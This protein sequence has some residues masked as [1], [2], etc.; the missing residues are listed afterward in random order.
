MG[1][2]A[3]VLSFVRSLSNGAK[4]TDVKSDP[5]GGAN[6]T[7]QHFAPAGDDS[8]PLDTDYTLLVPLPRSGGAAAVGYLDPSNTPKAEAGDKRIYARD[9]SGAVVAE[10]W[11]KNDGTAL[12]SNGNGSIE[13]APDG[14]TKATT[15][16]A[17]FEAAASGSIKGVNGSGSF[18]LQPG[19]N[20]V[21]NNVVIT[22]TGGITTPTSVTAATVAAST[23]LTAASTEIV[24]HTHTQ[25]PDSGGN[26]EQN[27][28]GPV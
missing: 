14:G 28:G 4:V 20:F 26:T 19:G 22:P 10:V 5:G 23:S 21:V 13:L 2:I 18:E 17:T 3:R 1:R 27:T 16:S 8:H 12:V 15:P 9:S 25:G 24:G 7:A 11:L 6:T